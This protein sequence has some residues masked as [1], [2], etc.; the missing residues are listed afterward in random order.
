[1]SIAAPF[2]HNASRLPRVNRA[3]TPYR[4]PP[5]A[6]R[7]SS[8][9]FALHHAQETTR[10][11][12]VAIPFTSIIEQT[13]DTYRKALGPYAERGIVEHHTNLL[14]EQATRRRR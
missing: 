8:L 6:A 12:V 7:L 5:G 2:W 14:P 3:S 11:V 9:A 13:A 1:M 10:R 4:Y